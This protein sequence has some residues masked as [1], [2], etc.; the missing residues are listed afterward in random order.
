[1]GLF[2][3]RTISRPLIVAAERK[4][5]EVC[6]WGSFNGMEVCACAC[7]CVCVC[8]GGRSNGGGQS[9]GC[10]SVSCRPPVLVTNR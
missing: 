8:E 2:F 5:V 10:R 1:M 6:R 3:H 9:S 7:V 4:G